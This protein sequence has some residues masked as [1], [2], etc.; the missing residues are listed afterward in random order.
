MILETKNEAKEM[1]HFNGR[2]DKVRYSIKKSKVAS[3]KNNQ[4]P[5]QFTTICK[6]TTSTKDFP[7]H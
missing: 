4:P 2:Q 3:E 7:L 5:P 6:K 1:V